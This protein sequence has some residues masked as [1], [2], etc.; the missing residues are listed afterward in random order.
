MN[1]RLSSDAL[2]DTKVPKGIF[3]YPCAG[4]DINS[5]ILDFHAIVNEFHFADINNRFLV[6][7]DRIPYRTSDDISFPRNKFVVEGRPTKPLSEP[8][9]TL[10]PEGVRPRIEPYK[11]E[12]ISHQHWTSRESDEGFDVFYHHQDGLTL[13]SRLKSI[14][15]FYLIGDSNGEGGSGQRWFQ[16]PTFSY[17]LEKLEDG[18]LIVTDGSS[19]DHG[20]NTSVWK[21]FWGG[22]T[23]NIN[24]RREVTSIPDDFDYKNR[25]FKCL[26]QAGWRYGPVFVWQV[27]NK[28]NL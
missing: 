28:N 1:G 24:N 6:W 19:R 23:R 3:F 27:H 9:D 18:G 11:E 2:K 10:F 26:G 15:I 21:E 14:S 7:F 16:E 4:G 17:L 22:T 20:D 5:P 12:V 8:G 25:Q 13:L